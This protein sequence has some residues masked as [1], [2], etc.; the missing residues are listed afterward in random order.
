MTGAKHDVQTFAGHELVP[1]T[2]TDGMRQAAR[3]AVCARA[4]DAADARQLLEACG[5]LPYR[6]RRGRYTYGSKP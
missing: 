5:L 4:R 3:L 6:R 2:V 1:V